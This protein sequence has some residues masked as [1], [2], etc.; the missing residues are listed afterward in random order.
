MPWHDSDE[1][2]YFV[3][4]S[5]LSTACCLHRTAYTYCGSKRPLIQEAFSNITC[6]CACVYLCYDYVP[7]T[8]IIT[9]MILSKA[10]VLVGS[11]ELAMFYAIQRLYRTLSYR[12]T[13]SAR[14]MLLSWYNRDLPMHT[15]KHRCAYI[16]GSL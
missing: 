1:R 10:C 9:I 5:K 2:E 16:S 13:Q 15:Y 8:V 11:R 3:S 12:F 6:V 14:S 7:T 4:F